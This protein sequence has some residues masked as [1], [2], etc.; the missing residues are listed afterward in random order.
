MATL[1]IGLFRKVAWCSMAEI[2]LQGSS[3][4]NSRYLQVAI[5][6]KKTATPTYFPSVSSQA[7]Y[8]IDSYVDLLVDHEF[9]RLLASCYDLKGRLPKDDLVSKINKF[10][11]NGNVLF[12]DSGLYESTWKKDNKF[13]FGEYR[14]SLSLVD[15]DFCSSFDVFHQP[16]EELSFFAEKTIKAIRDSQLQKSGSDL[17]PIVHGTSPQE[18]LQVVKKVIKAFDFEL[19]F[20]AVPERETGDDIVERARNL[21]KIRKLLDQQDHD[22]VLHLLGCGD[23]VSLILFIFFGVDSFDSLDWLRSVVD[24][25]ELRMRHLSHIGLINCDCPY[26]SS[27]NY[28]TFFKALLHNLY[29]Y[30]RFLENIRKRIADDEIADFVKDKIPYVYNKLG[31]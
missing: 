31:L 29:F 6:N 24:P 16:G 8:S 20:L 15:Y 7:R 30:S 9:P 22:T 10:S 4:R 3:G 26:C 11:T 18:L 25:K 28:S 5:N 2:T 1:I 17:V 19:H 13:S 27:S 12:L 23:P 21:E 14:Q